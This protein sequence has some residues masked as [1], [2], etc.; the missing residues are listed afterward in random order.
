[1]KARGLGIALAIA[2]CVALAAGGTALGRGAA[3]TQVTIHY[4]GDGFQGRVKSGRHKCVA[5]RKVIVYK[6]KGA[7]PDRSV[8]RQWSSDTTGGDG[9]WSD[10]NSGPGKGKYYAFAKR[11]P[12]CR[13][14]LSE[15]IRVVPTA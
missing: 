7:E 3:K 1:M 6:Q 8:D 10:G 11:K 14:G 15:T 12:G 4:N 5:D 2:A 9:H 13:R